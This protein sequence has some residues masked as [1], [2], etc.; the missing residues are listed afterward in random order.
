[1]NTR[2]QENLR[3]MAQIPNI[4]NEEYFPYKEACMRYYLPIQPDSL[5]LDVGGGHDP[6]QWA[7]LVI[8]KYP[9]DTYHRDGAEAKILKD[10]TIIADATRLPF[11]DKSFDFIFCKHVVEHM[12]DR[13]Q[14]TAILNELSRIGKFGLITS[15]SE[16]CERILGWDFHVWFVNNKDGK[17]LFRKKQTPLPPWGYLIRVTTSSES[18]NTREWS[19]LY[20]KFIP[21]F[22]MQYLWEDSI[23]F[24]FIEDD[25]MIFPY[26]DKKFC[27]DYVQNK[28]TVIPNW[29]EKKK[30]GIRRKLFLKKREKTK[31]ERLKRAFATLICPSCRSEEMEKEKNKIICRNCSKEYQKNNGVWNLDF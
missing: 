2:K 12:K 3:N 17:I 23:E 19:D 7:D 4:H 13:E 1:M 9:N 11:K 25:E 21:F 24:D 27:L 10:K 22:E 16:I 6:V 26:E 8:D 5:V 29:I 28:R 14:V 15:P 30:D 20:N 18:R 31:Q